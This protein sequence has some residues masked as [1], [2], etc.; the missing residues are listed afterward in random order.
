METV[1]FYLFGDFLMKRYRL[2]ILPDIVILLCI[3]VLLLAFF[4]D[5]AS[6]SVSIDEEPSGLILETT[7]P[8]EPIT[9]ES[10]LD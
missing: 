7:I 5:A 1:N 4:T 6:D 2:Q 8:Y 9:D 3:T 10:R